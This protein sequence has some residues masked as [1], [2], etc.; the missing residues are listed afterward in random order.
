MPAVLAIRAPKAMLRLK[1]LAGLKRMMP[2][3]G[4]FGQVVRMN[5]MRPPGIV[6]FLERHT[7]ELGPLR[8]EVI[9][10]AAG[11]RRKD[12]LRHGI[13]NEP[14]SLFTVANY[15]LGELPFS[16]ILKGQQD[17]RSLIGRLNQS[18]GVQS[19]RPPTDFFELV[20]HLEVRNVILQRQ[21]LDQQPPQVGDVPLSVAQFKQRSVESVLRH[22]LKRLVERAAGGLNAQ[23][24]IQHQQ[25]FADC[26]DDALGILVSALDRIHIDQHYDD[27]VDQIVHSSVGAESQRIPVAL[28]VANFTFAGTCSVEHRFQK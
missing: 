25:W 10:V 27:A 1:R 20:F 28:L 16:D 5:K 7:R 13:H 17:Q 12:F 15:M 24:L 6:H 9:N 14:Q 8:I 18:P 19:H 4:F 22:D 23:V 11:C 3:P 26:G 21:H 2:M